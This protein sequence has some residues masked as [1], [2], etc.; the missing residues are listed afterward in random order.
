MGLPA[1][2]DKE[3]ALTIIDGLWCYVIEPARIYYSHIEVTTDDY[4]KCHVWVCVADDAVDNRE[5][6]DYFACL[7]RFYS[8]LPEAIQKEIGPEELGNTELIA[9]IDQQQLPAEIDVAPR[10]LT[11]GILPV[12]PAA[13]ADARNYYP[14]RTLWFTLPD[15][16]QIVEFVTALSKGNGRKT[17]RVGKNA[18]IVAAG[19]H[20]YI[21]NM[22][23][24]GRVSLDV[25]IV[26]GFSE[27]LTVEQQRD[28]K[29]RLLHNTPEPYKTMLKGLGPWS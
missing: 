6:W 27:A 4:T 13:D 15:T 23:R 29:R 25:Y 2:R 22:S 3:H 16:V 18:Y 5:A 19:K 26:K 20:R 17:Y 14:G 1:Y 11:D 8:L 7:E 10:Q 9:K 12:L 28:E 24:S 21:I